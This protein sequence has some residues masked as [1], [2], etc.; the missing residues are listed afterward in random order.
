MQTGS[1][2]KTATA[3]AEEGKGRREKSAL[4][5]AGK[6]SA[7]Y[8]RHLKTVKTTRRQ[9]VCVKERAAERAREGEWAVGTRC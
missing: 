2:Q 5:S 3:T 7:G 6:A 4:I 8:E 1:A 9:Q